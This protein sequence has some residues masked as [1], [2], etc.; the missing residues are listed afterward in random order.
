M[1]KCEYCG[2]QNEDNEPH[3]LQCGTAF[4]DIESPEL[5]PHAGSKKPISTSD[6]R[7]MVRGTFWFIGGGLVTA[8]TYAAA[9]RG[10]FGGT[11]VVAWGAMLYG[12]FQWYAGWKGNEERAPEDNAYAELGHATALEARGRVQEA[13]LAYKGILERYPDSAAAQ[14]AKKSIESLW[15]QLRPPKG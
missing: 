13:L 4:P 14:D 2:Q 15:S 8:I 11:Y 3:C 12:A 7:R 9:L 1:K 10:T 5:D 6:N